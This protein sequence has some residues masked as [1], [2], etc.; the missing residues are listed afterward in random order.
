[1]A[2]TEVE[3]EDEEEESGRYTGSS[4]WVDAMMLTGLRQTGE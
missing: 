4:T 2:P 3:E 1:V